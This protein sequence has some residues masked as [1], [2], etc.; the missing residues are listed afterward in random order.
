MS[1]N[2]ELKKMIVK[3]KLEIANTCKNDYLNEIKKIAQNIID[4]DDLARLSVNIKDM[5]RFYVDF[6]LQTGIIE[7]IEMATKNQN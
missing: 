7:G 6:M 5:N 2:L 1:E 4:T 3:Q